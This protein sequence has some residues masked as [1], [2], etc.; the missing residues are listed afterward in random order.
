MGQLSFSLSNLN[1]AES[2]LVL[3]LELTGEAPVLL[4]NSHGVVD[5]LLG[6]VTG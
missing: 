3:G 1:G 5:E 6:G 2:E 4:V